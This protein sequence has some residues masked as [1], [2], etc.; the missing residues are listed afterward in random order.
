[1]SSMDLEKLKMTGAGRAIAVLTSGG[2]AQGDPKTQ[3]S[4][5]DN[6]LCGLWVHVQTPGGF[7]CRARSTWEGKRPSGWGDASWQP[8]PTRRGA[9]VEPS[10]L[11][12]L[13]AGRLLM[14][15]RS[16]LAANVHY[17]YCTVSN[18]QWWKVTTFTQVLY[19]STI[20][21]ITCTLRGYFR[22]LLLSTSPPPQIGGK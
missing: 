15:Q 18:S 19:S 20:W 1:M 21:G 8:G 14:G 22:C 13:T 4:C 16:C 10:D 7:Y 17:R 3:P 6:T 12:E 2:D 11:R 9:A 5:P